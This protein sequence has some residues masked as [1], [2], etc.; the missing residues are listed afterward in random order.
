MYG[1]IWR[2]LPFGLRGK[3]VAS[4]GLT[5]AVVALL[6]YV[7]FPWLEPLAPFDDVQ[8]GTDGDTSQFDDGGVTDGGDPSNHPG[9][10]NAIPY[11]TES[12]N[13][14]PSGGR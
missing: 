7:I 3:L 12:N 4:I 13:P 2:K 11:D 10:D 6:W 8:V 1:W 14:A 5:L 9:D